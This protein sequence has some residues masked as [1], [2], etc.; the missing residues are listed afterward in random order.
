[1]E[2][3]SKFIVENRFR[4]FGFF[5]VWCA[6]IFLLM[7]F[8]PLV[9]AVISLVYFIGAVPLAKSMKGVVQEMLYMGLLAL[10]I[11]LPLGLIYANS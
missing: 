4:A 3:S 7:Y 11:C 6:L 10:V 2:E 1:M 9:L 5:L 8:Y